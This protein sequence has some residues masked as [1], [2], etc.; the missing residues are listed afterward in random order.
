MVNKR[1]QNAVPGCN[2]KND[3][4]ISVRLQGKPFNITVIQVYAPTSNTEEAEVE[5]FYEDLQDFLELTPKKDV[6]CD[7]M[8]CRLPGSSLHGILQA[9]VLE[10]VTIS[11]SRGT[12]RPRDRTRVSSIP[13]RCFNLWTTR[14]APKSCPILY[15]P[16]NWST[17]GFPVLHGP[18]EFA[19]THAHWISDAIQPS[20]PLSPPS[21]PALYLSQHQ[22][23]FNESALYI[24]WP[25]YWSFSL[26]ISPSNEYSFIG[27]ISLLLVISVYFNSGDLFP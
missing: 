8:D 27:G 16:I 1:V 20:H 26:G 19:Q 11:F 10:W 6:L 3:R 23:L 15:N 12:S 24:R 25:K 18:P 7:R 22:G 4:M 2:L 13:G 9:R 14:E 5:W 21:P 17:P